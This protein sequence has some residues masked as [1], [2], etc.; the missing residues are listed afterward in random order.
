MNI[1]VPVSWLREYLKTELNTK[2][3]ANYLTLS[4]PSVERIEK[5]GDDYIFDVEVTSNRPDAFSVFGLAREANAILKSENQ[6][7]EL[8][9]PPGLNLNL[10]PDTA[11]K[12]PLEVLI[13]NQ[14]L[15]PRFSAII[16]DNVKIKPSPAYI[17]NRLKAS[18]V[19][20]INN[21]VDISNY[22]MLE[23]GQPMH[24]FDFDKIKGAKMI[25]RESQIGEKIQTIDGQTRKLPTGTI[26]IEDAQRL[27]DLCGIMG[28]ANSQIS[29]RTKRVV[30]FVQAYDP[31]RIRKTTQALAFRTEAA[32][33]FEKGLDL[34]GIMPALKRAA[35]LAKETSG[36]KI[37]SELID[38]YKNKPK[39]RQINLNF[40][41]LE[42]YLGIN[43]PSETTQKILNLLGFK[44]SLSAQV[45][46]AIP[47][48]WRFTDVEAE[49]DLIEEIARIYG[50][51]KL[52]STLPTGQIPSQKDSELIEVIELKKALKYLGL[53]E[54]ISYSIISK[55]FLNLTQISK[56]DAVEL[57]NPLTDQWQFMRPTLLVSQAAI[58]SQNQNI[59]SDL[60][61]F[62]IAKTYIASSPSQS[63]GSNLPIQ[64]IK[65]AICLQDSDF[66]KIKS[67]VESLFEILK[68]EVKFVQKPENPLFENN[69]SARIAIGDQTVGTLGI[70]N[71]KITDYFE[72]ET[73]IAAAELN[74]S[75]IYQIQ[76]LPLSYKPI[77]KYPPVIE[78]I[79]AI[80]DQKTAIGD[81]VTLTKETAGTILKKIT[82]I[83]IFEDE[84]IGPNKK[85]V[86]LRLVFQKPDSTPTQNEV[87]Q[88]RHKIIT[89]LEKT[90]KAQ[91]R[92]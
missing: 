57:Q 42:D 48:S 77:S 50:Y 19:R 82:L 28:A 36:A 45:I 87:Y 9:K 21:I 55:D 14:S 22:V 74:L 8:E 90:F 44:T 35:Y 13:K 52:P 65:L 27:I 59:A 88:Q 40:K 64:D 18:G 67:I 60:K 23:L 51:H 68:R 34:E 38:I 78:D 7:S 12:L 47:P 17:K 56:E 66:Y 20:A 43:L 76:R 30:I 32:A 72:I 3:V 6:K 16:I 1:R 41:R 63:Q 46:S 69:Q 4:G 61:L 81:I 11:K 54:V 85:S 33:R 15:C 5:Y 10:E 79:S 25:L 39:P 71:Q 31:K 49:E 73:Q 53:T 84:K 2:T 91:I 37:A 62:E 75:T 83:D 86:T 58:I 70:L 89:A 92:K 29:S 80:F 24:T 26:V